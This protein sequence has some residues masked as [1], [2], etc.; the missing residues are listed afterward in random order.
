MLSPRAVVKINT[1]TRR[2]STD[3]GLYFSA[4]TRCRFELDPSLWLFSLGSFD[5]M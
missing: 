2:P 3:E 4:G 5:G 1:N